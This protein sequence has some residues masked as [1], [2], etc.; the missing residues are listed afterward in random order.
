MDD[1]AFGIGGAV[2]VGLVVAMG[3][4]WGLAVAFRAFAR[5]QPDPVWKPTGYQTPTRSW[6][7]SRDHDRAERIT[8][9]RAIVDA[10]HRKIAAQLAM[11]IQFLAKPRKVKGD[12]VV[13]FPA[14]RM[15]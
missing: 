1:M 12:R 3:L 4:G 14:R 11:P 10:Q 2:L 9:R 13:P 7:V 5:R 15:R 8:Q 6:D